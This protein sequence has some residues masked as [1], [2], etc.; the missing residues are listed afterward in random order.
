MC[1]HLQTSASALANT[2]YIMPADSP[3]DCPHQPCL[4]LYRYTKTN[5]F[6][7][8]TTLLFL[9]G[10]HTLQELVLNLSS[11][12]DITLRGGENNSDVN[13]ICTSTVTIKCKNVTGLKIEGLTFL[14]NNIDYEV[15]ALELI[16][17]RNVLILNITFQGS[18]DVL[19][20]KRLRAT[21][22]QHSTATIRNSVFKW[23]V[24]SAIYIQDDSILTICGSSFTRNKGLGNG[25]AVY[26][27]ESTLLLDG[28]TPNHFTHNSDEQKGGAI[29][30]KYN[31]TLE[32]KG[33]SKLHAQ[34]LVRSLLPILCDR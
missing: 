9:P 5:N 6:T 19:N 20:S 31:C 7:T 3:S 16:N 25:G 27:Q 1:L 32:M 28:S 21:F 34:I 11:V 30:C 22:F 2:S 12:S 10:N 18:E 14:L 23:N 33:I 4:T 24:G 13:I 29:Q 17:C 15:T 8:G 26:A